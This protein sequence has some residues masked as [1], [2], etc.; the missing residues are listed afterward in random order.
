MAKRIVVT[1]EQIEEAHRLYLKEGLSMD[2]IG[3]M[4]GQIVRNDGRVGMESVA[5][6]DACDTISGL[7]AGDTATDGQDYPSI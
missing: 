6:A 3:Q 7:E 5:S 2:A 1:P 4:Y